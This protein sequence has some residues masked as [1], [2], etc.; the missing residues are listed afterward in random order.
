[1]DSRKFKIGILNTETGKKIKEKVVNQ[2]EALR[3]A[4]KIAA[5][6][7][8]QD[9][10]FSGKKI[11]DCWESI[12][13][14]EK[15]KNIILGNGWSNIAVESIVVFKGSKSEEHEFYIERIKEDLI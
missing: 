1:M 13:I 10:F 2:E 14:A 12:G 3:I 4:K 9:T 7:D 6:F 5:W 15:F 11:W 8:K